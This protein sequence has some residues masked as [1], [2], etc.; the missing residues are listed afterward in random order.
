VMNVQT[1]QRRCRHLQ[2]QV[3]PCHQKKSLI[4]HTISIFFI[5]V[6]SNFWIMIW[7]W[8]RNGKHKPK[9]WSFVFLDQGVINLKVGHMHNFSVIREITD[10]L[11]SYRSR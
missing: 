6:S 9:T 5:T 4:I 7:A 11:C 2:L 3:Q 1:R 10:Q 8:Y